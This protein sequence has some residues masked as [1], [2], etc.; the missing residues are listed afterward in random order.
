MSSIHLFHTYYKLSK[1]ILRLLIKKKAILSI[2]LSLSTAKLQILS[3]FAS[4]LC[5]NYYK[6]AIY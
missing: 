2:F 5:I 4:S 6:K 3:I 1:D